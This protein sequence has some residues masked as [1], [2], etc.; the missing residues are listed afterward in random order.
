LAHAKPIHHPPDPGAWNRPWTDVPRLIHGDKAVAGYGDR[1]FYV[2]VIPRHLACRMIVEH[3]YSKGFV[4]NSYVHLGVFLDGA[5]RGVLQ[6]GYA[7]T[8][9]FMSRVVAGTG[10]ADYLE[11]NRMWLSD[12][13]PRNSESRAI[14]FAIKYIRAAMP[15]VRW[16]QSYA[17]ERCGRLGVVYQ[18][19]NFL[20]VGCHRTAFYELDGETYHKM[21]LTAHGK[22][23]RRGP[24][25]RANLHRATR[26][27]LRQFRYVFFLHPGARNHLRLKVQP[28]PKPAGAAGKDA[29]GQ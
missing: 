8:P 16:I 5:L 4:R 21:L 29:A 25:L 23:G 2:A 20:Y 12:L 7:L 19:A 6:L 3:H 15:H 28:Y 24:H 1:W 26:R 10:S 13:A 17:D 27:D 11:L 18:A 14:A 22:D 9:A